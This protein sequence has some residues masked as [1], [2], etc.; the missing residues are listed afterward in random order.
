MNAKADVPTHMSEEPPLTQSIG[1]NGMNRHLLK[2][3]LQATGRFPAAGQR[4]HAA[5]RAV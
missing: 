2:R 3:L 5:A 1:Q 4:C